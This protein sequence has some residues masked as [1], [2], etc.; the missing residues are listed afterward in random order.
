[1]RISSSEHIT[2]RQRLIIKACLDFPGGSWV[3]EEVRLEIDFARI[4]HIT[5]TFLHDL[6]VRKDPRQK[7]DRQQVIQCLAPYSSMKISTASLLAQIEWLRME[8]QPIR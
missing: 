6:S 7:A 5:N 3:D 4:Q 8:I 2:L 1:M